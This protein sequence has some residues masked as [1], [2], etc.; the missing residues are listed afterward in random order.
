MAKPTKV[1]GHDCLLV[2]EDDIPKIP[3]V[4]GGRREGDVLPAP[5]DAPLLVK[6]WYRRG[7]HQHHSTLLLRRGKNQRAPSEDYTFFHYYCYLHFYL[8]YYCS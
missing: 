4:P 1:V 2:T 3:Y 6:I 5:G 7:G 8:Y